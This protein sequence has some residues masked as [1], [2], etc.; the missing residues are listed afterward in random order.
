MLLKKPVFEAS[1]CTH[2]PAAAS[3]TCLWDPWLGSCA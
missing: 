3:E 1:L 2:A